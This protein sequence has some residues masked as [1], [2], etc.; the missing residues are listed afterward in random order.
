MTVCRM[1]CSRSRSPRSEMCES[2]RFQRLSPPPVC[3]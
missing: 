1:T 2:G 3:I